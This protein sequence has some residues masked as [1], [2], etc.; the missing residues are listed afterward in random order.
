MSYRLSAE[1]K[2]V[3]KLVANF[4]QSPRLYRTIMGD[5]VTEVAD[6]V[7]RGAKHNAPRKTSTLAV[8]INF[9]GPKYSGAQI[10]ATVGT[11]LKYAP[12]QEFGTGVFAGNGPIRPKRGKVLAWKSGG[13]TIFARSVQ[14]IKGKRFF[15]QSFESNQG[16]AAEI[17]KRALAEWIRKV[18]A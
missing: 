16:V 17:F 4:V 10:T 2:N 13:K 14:G 8:S 11:K 6:K 3:D 1:I 9:E 12:Y 15:G 5:A 18:A 7:V